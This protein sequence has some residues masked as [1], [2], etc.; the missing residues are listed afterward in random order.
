MVPLITLSTP[1]P[2][3][4]SAL[5]EQSLLALVGH[6]IRHKAQTL[7]SVPNAINRTLYYNV[8]QQ[9]QFMGLDVASDCKKAGMSESDIDKALPSDSGA[10]ARSL[11]PE[12]AAT[13]SSE[14]FASKGRDIAKWMR[15][16]LEMLQISRKAGQTKK[17]AAKI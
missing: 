6:E 8:A 7:S 16:P 4:L 12:L 13:H 1:A 3:L 15:E 11:V 2:K 10:L 9:A 14:L 5:D 17:N